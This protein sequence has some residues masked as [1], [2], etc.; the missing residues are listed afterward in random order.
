MASQRRKSGMLE[1]DQLTPKPLKIKKRL[2]LSDEEYDTTASPSMPII[3]SS[4]SA[5][6][7]YSGTQAARRS[8]L[9]S[10]LDEVCGMAQCDYSEDEFM[11]NSMVS[12]AT[13]A[14][15]RGPATL[16]VRKTRRSTA[17]PGS[18][19][20]NV[21]VKASDDGI[22]AAHSTTMTQYQDTRDGHA[23]ADFDKARLVLLD[24]ENI[25]RQSATPSSVSE[26]FLRHSYR[27]KSCAARPSSDYEDRVN[28]AAVSQSSQRVLGRQSS[29]K[30]RFLNRLASGFG[31]MIPAY[32]LSD[33]DNCECEEPRKR[34]GEVRD[35]QNRSDNDQNRI[36]AK[37]RCVTEPSSSMRSSFESDLGS[38]IAS[39]PSPPNSFFTII[40]SP[41]T[42]QT[43]PDAT[44]TALEQYRLTRPRR[45]NSMSSED[46][47][48]V[49]VRLTLVPEN[50]RVVTADLEG[51]I[52]FFVAIEIEGIVCRV[53][54]D[55][56]PPHDSNRLDLAVVIDNSLYT[57]PAALM[58]ACESVTAI[59]H[60]LTA[61]SDR[62]ALFHTSPDLKKS[63]SN[64]KLL[65]LGEPN[66]WNLK[67]VLDNVEV[68]AG[69]PE[70]NC[71]GETIALAQSH[72]K[73]YPRA[74]SINNHGQ[75]TVR[76][77]IVFTSRPHTVP[78]ASC[79]EESIGV[80]VICAGSLPWM[81]EKPLTGDGWYM[82]FQP[83]SRE[84]ST[85]GKLKDERRLGDRFRHLIYMLRASSVPGV[86]SGLELLVN[87][88]RFCTVKKIIGPT[89]LETLRAG[90]VVKTIVKIQMSAPQVAADKNPDTWHEKLSSSKYDNLTAV[91]DGVLEEELITI[92]DAEVRYTHSL[93]PDG[94]I[95]HAKSEA[96]V[97][98]VSSLLK[99]RNE[100][101]WQE[102]VTLSEGPGPEAAL[103]QKSLMYHLATTH[104][105]AS[106]LKLLLENFGRDVGLSICP[107]YLMLLVAELKYQGRV[108]SRMNSF[109]KDINERDYKRGAKEISSLTGN[110]APRA[111]VRPE[112][113]LHTDIDPFPEQNRRA[114]ID[115][116]TDSTRGS[117]D[118]P[119][120]YWDEIRRVSKGR[121]SSMMGL[122]R[123]RRS[124]HV[125]EEQ[126]RIQE[127][128]VMNGR[129]IRPESLDEMV[130][131]PRGKENL[132]PWL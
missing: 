105:P 107:E 27:S 132:A 92:L 86:L 13:N 36:P 40:G 4:S 97:Q 79:S 52:T 80:H 119:R 32:N 121:L 9:I 95:C 123:T 88:G 84:L 108:A 109:D 48:V 117:V 16:I 30:L 12:P 20:G 29:Y 115:L 76:Q 120:K 58:S 38:T 1:M 103:V 78:S 100:N 101:Q 83:T 8:S 87:G 43:S 25:M 2:C 99:Q 98:V 104:T 131:D 42:T 130:Y 74:S 93:L 71:L 111:S 64:G 85:L 7:R 41:N 10:L 18:S 113:W 118:L 127:L 129:S 65:S 55:T 57:S 49:G 125:I 114:T 61:K 14:S 37:L 62:F 50:N 44:R 122:G 6:V 35:A 89:K 23:C 34:S 82:C 116:V 56:Y 91:L 126:R 26:S 73:S 47:R 70:P 28:A 51:G 22:S 24:T 72:L 33:G 67:H 106:A 53:S 59:A 112:R 46:A 102:S 90:E 31:T 63:R 69:V 96:R 60:S 68:C 94:T 3:P 21:A 110:I 45:P 39:F 128:A 81:S 5:M 19:A 124:S 17:V 66:L 15:Q 11:E 75:E 54:K 77:I